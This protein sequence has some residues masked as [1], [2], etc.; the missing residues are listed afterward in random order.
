MHLFVAMFYHWTRLQEKTTF[1]SKMKRMAYACLILYG[2][3]H[4]DIM[5]TFMH[6]LVKCFILP[7]DEIIREITFFEN[8]EKGLRT[9]QPNL[10]FQL[11]LHGG[12]HNDI[13]SSLLSRVGSGW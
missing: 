11:I 8:E 6:L 9:T 1:F 10:I 13:M 7:L 3:L 12:I 4:N 5:T 2:G